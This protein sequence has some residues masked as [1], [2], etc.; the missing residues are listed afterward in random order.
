MQTLAWKTVSANWVQDSVRTA[1][2]NFTLIFFFLEV[3]FYLFING[4]NTKTIFVFGY[5]AYSNIF[6]FFFFILFCFFLSFFLYSEHQTNSLCL[7]FTLF[8]DIQQEGL[9]LL[10]VLHKLL[11]TASALYFSFFHSLKSSRYLSS[12]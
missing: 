3:Y 4:T 1:F 2:I 10:Q 5:T 8:P 7:L 11:V 6:Q 12:I 9:S